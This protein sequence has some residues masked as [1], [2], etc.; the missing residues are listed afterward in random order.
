MLCRSM[1]DSIS[2][3]SRSLTIMAEAMRSTR[4]STGGEEGE[5]WARA[6]DLVGMEGGGGVAGEVEEP[7][8]LSRR[9]LRGMWKD[10]GE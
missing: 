5:V 1:M 2:A 3:S 7:K 6:R 4:A 10:M 8:E 9:C